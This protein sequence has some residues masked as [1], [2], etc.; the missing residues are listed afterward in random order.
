MARGQFVLENPQGLVVR[1]YSWDAP[2]INLV[3]R[4]DTK[5]VEAHASTETLKER[6]ARFK[7]LATVTPDEVKRSSKKIGSFGTLRYVDQVEKVSVS[8]P[9]EKE[10]TEEFKKIFGYSSA[11]HLVLVGLMLITGVIINKFFDAPKEAP[12]VITIYKDEIPELRQEKRQVVDASPTKL[13][14][15][16]KQQQNIDRKAKASNRTVDR[17]NSH[18]DASKH[19]S[20]VGAAGLDGSKGGVLGVLGSANRQGTGRGGF[21]INNLKSSGGFGSA[22]YGGGYGGHGAGG[23]NR[24]IFGSGLIAGNPGPGSQAVGAGGYGTKGVGGGGRTGYGKLQMVGGSNGYFQP[25]ETEAEIS[26]GLD[27]DQIAEVIRRHMG[28]VVNCY[29]QALQKQ[30]N[31]SGRMNTKFIIGGSGSV[32]SAQVVH[33]SVKSAAV[34]SCVI[35]R[36]RSWKF[37]KPQGNVDVRVSYPFAFRRVGQG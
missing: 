20:A 25:L 19:K 6:K 29:E 28:E 21:N 32:A 22:K 27:H 4:L 12:Q 10:N 23:I 8:V 5:R 18:A 26:G 3:Y 11:G 13:K 36:L 17:T 37:P 31:L 34:E 24:A 9:L 14:E 2:E 30:P 15:N 7:V 16:V 1:T 33:S 35:S